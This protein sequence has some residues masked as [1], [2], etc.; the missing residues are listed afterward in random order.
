MNSIKRIFD[1]LNF[2]KKSRKTRKNKVY[3][4]DFN[5]EKTVDI[6]IPNIQNKSFKVSKWFVK[7]GSHIK[8]NQVICELESNSISLEFDSQIDGKLVCI[9][10]KQG[11]LKSKDILCK[12]ETL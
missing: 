9:T 4:I 1:L 8:K 5:P 2:N 7:V 12:I 11:Y 6:R 10:N 3:K